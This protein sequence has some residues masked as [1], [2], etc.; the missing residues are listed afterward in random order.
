M[1]PDHGF[2]FK[3]KERRINMVQIFVFFVSGI[4]VGILIGF[5]GSEVLSGVIS[6]VFLII[7]LYFTYKTQAPSDGSLESTQ[8]LKPFPLGAIA[9]LIFAIALGSLASMYMRSNNILVQS[10][11][12][13]D[14][15]DLI[16]IGVDESAAR[17]I[18]SKAT[19]QSGLSDQIV[20]QGGEITPAKRSRLST[21]HNDTRLIFLASR[22]INSENDSENLNLT[23]IQ[24]AARRTTNYLRA[25]LSELVSP[26]AVEVWTRLYLLDD[27]NQKIAFDEL[28]EPDKQY[29]QE[30]NNA[31]S[32]N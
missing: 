2:Q 4:S 19:I 1:V 11:I 27:E 24:N 3:S 18:V 32:Q 22:Q 28:S 29:V 25:E 20:L 30:V 7:T 13:K 8:P 16:G 26:K 6:A 10:P 15:Y 14:Y 23:Q 5:S 17:E 21:L 31:L 9:S 12:V